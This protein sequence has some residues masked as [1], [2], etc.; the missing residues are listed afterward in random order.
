MR[1]FKN[2]MIHILSLG[3]CAFGI[4][5]A[6]SL[7]QNIMAF[8]FPTSS[9][10]A[11]CIRTILAFAIAA[12]CPSIYATAYC[13][14]I[15][16]LF[17]IIAYHWP[18]YVSIPDYCD[19]VQSATDQ[20]LSNSTNT[21]HPTTEYHPAEYRSF[22]FYRQIFDLNPYDVSLIMAPQFKNHANA[23]IWI[24]SIVAALSILIPRIPSVIVIRFLQFEGMLIMLLVIYII[25]GHAKQYFKP[26]QP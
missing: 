19:Y 5:A 26:T 3:H 12:Y 10:I 13:E 2:F 1:R 21:N 20:T 9:L 4:L 7:I 22:H 24:N 6:G 18:K 8:F 11:L 14:V 23:Y 15:N 25:T 16:D 17:Y